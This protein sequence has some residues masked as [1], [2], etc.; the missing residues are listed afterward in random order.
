MLERSKAIAVGAIWAILARACFVRVGSIFM[1]KMDWMSPAGLIAAM[2]LFDVS[3]LEKLT[4]LEV[5]KPTTVRVT[6]C[7]P[8]GLIMVMV[9]PTPN[10]PLNG[11]VAFRKAGKTMLLLLASDAFR[12]RPAFMVRPGGTTPLARS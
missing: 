6:R 1:E 12:L 2:A 3:T 11:A 8:S 9:V 10:F 4:E 5:Y 7:L